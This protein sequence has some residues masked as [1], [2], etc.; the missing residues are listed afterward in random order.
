MH[1][2]I[3]GAALID[4]IKEEQ[5][6]NGQAVT[7]LVLSCTDKAFNTITNAKQVYQNAYEMWESL[8]KT[9]KNGFQD[10]KS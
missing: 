4:G 7:Y 10:W 6:T 8:Q 2:E 1:P 5:K 3:S 9:L